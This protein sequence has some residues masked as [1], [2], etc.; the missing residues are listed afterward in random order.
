MSTPKKR[1][2]TWSSDQNKERNQSSRPSPVRRFPVGSRFLNRTVERVKIK[3][4]WSFF[5]RGERG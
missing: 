3:K 4:Q 5:L 1:W 2:N